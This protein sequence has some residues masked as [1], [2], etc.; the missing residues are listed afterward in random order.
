MS[1]F[2]FFVC[3]FLYVFLIFSFFCVG[4]VNNKVV[5]GLSYPSTLLLGMLDAGSLPV[6]NGHS[7]AIN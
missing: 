4:Q 3:S 2:C 5:S 1:V 7:F 6:L